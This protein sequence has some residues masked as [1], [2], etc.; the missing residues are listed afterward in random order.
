MRPK[1][2]TMDPL[3]N[4]KFEPD[5]NRQQSKSLTRKEEKQ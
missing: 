3:S 1:K 2:M 4:N 5:I